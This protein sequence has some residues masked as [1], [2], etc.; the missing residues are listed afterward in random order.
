M[1]A[2]DPA[3]ATDVEDMGMLGDVL[4]SY[5]IGGEA[6]LWTSFTLESPAPVTVNGMSVS[7]DF[8][9]A[10]FGPDGAALG[11]AGPVAA[12]SPA[13]VALDLGPGK[14]LVALTNHGAS[15][16]ILRQ[17]TVTRN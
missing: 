9:V 6:T 17:V 2:P 10:V 5:T 12:M 4:R 7:S 13:D 3:A 1:E 15:G 16:T 14:Y 8:S 11:E